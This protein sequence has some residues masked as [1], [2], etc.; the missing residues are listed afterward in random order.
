FPIA[1]LL[2]SGGFLKVLGL[3]NL[4]LE[5]A[6]MWFLLGGVIAFAQSRSR[7]NWVDSARNY[8]W[9][10][11]GLIGVSLLTSLIAPAVPSLAGTLAWITLLA[12]LVVLA[13]ILYLLH[14]VKGE[15]AKSTASPASSTQQD[16]TRKEAA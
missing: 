15:A 12:T 16:E 7:Q 3:V 1:F 6:L 11:L 8:R 14:Q 13:A 10:Y 2:F 9:A 4:I 5:G